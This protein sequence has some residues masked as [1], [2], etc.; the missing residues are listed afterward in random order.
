MTRLTKWMAGLAG[1]AALGGGGYWGYQQ[2]QASNDP[3]AVVAKDGKGDAKGNKA[4]GAGAEKGKGDGKGEGKGESKG[5]G[6]GKSKG[7]RGQAAPV[8]VGMARA[9]NV[10]IY[11]NGL[12][13]VTPTRT[14]TVRSRVDGELLRVHF[15]EGQ[16]VK[17]GQLLAEVDPRP[18]QAQLLQA[19]GQMQRDQAQLANARIDLERYRTLLKQDSIAE[20]QVASQEALVKQLEGTVK[21]DQ[22][23]VDNARLQVTYSRVTA[24]ISGQL[25][26]RQVDPGNVVRSGDANGIVVITQVKPITVLFTIPQD[27]LPRVLKRL[28]DG[29]RLPVEVFDRDQ[30]TRLGRGRLLTADNQIDTTTGTVKLKAQ[31]PN[32]EGNLFPNQFVNVRMLVDTREDAITVPSSALQRG[33]QGIFVYVL[34]EDRTVS[35]RNVKT[36]PVDGTRIVVES[37]VAAGERVVIDG[38]DRLRDGMR[39]EIADRESAFKGDGKGKGKGKGRR[40]KA[41][42]EAAGE[43]AKGNAAKGDTPKGDIKDDGK[44]D[45][46]RESK[47]KGRPEKGDAADGERPR[48]KGERAGSEGAKSDFADGERPPGKGGAKGEKGE[49][50]ARRDRRPDD[51]GASPDAG[52]SERPTKAREGRGEKGD[53]AREATP[54]DIAKE[55]AMEGIK[56]DAAGV[57]AAK[58]ER[59]DKGEG[60][61]KGDARKKAKDAE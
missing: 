37:G 59:G 15:R 28:R 60:R 27:D 56:P 54:A 12:G 8:A 25:G 17:Q 45:G 39:V 16:A 50:K 5:K 40:D 36:G 18:F 6:D 49:G 26:L 58:A 47:G 55:A 9:G 44:G 51:A 10:N 23:Q 1:A 13:T 2:W 21:V 11:L 52:D 20:Q 43:A 57:D 38:M 33:A 53:R 31:L 35:M 7:G 29:E 42:D 24:P 46:R 34:N 32:D 30:K 3:A 48:R 41:V 4:D 61:R 14:V 22:G 19:Q